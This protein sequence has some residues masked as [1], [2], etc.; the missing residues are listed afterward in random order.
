ATTEERGVLDVACGT[1]G[2]HYDML[3]IPAGGSR[4]PLS[5]SVRN[6]EQRDGSGNVRSPANIQMM[7]HDLLS[8]VSS[9]I[10]DHVNGLL[11]RNEV[12]LDAVDWIVFHQASSV[13]LDTLTKQLNADPAK[14]IRHLEMV[15][16]TVSAS[17][18][19]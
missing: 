7:G 13:V 2:E 17:I 3:L 12:S 8:F 9:R 15:G 18:P 16:N 10:P 6:Q 4:Q 1:A 14:V 5:D 19:I 11:A